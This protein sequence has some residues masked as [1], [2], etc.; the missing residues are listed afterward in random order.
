MLVSVVVVVMV[1]AVLVVL[2]RLLQCHL[3]LLLLVGPHRQ[4]LV[5]ARRVPELPRVLLVLLLRL[6]LLAG[7]L[8]GPGRGFG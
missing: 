4:R 7:I 6:R 3:E 5:L 1:V 2:V 8:L